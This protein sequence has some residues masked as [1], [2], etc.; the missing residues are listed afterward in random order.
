[1][2]D[3]LKYHHIDISSLNFVKFLIKVNVY[4]VYKANG[5][6]VCIHKCEANLDFD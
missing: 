5:T 1:M 6:T 2:F 4:N 3:L